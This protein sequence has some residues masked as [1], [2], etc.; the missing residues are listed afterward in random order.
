MARL[1][2]FSSKGYFIEGGALLVH[3]VEY[4]KWLS[5]Q[6]GKP[7]R[8]P[9]EAEWEYAARSAGEDEIWAGTSEE[10]QLSR[11][12]VCSNIEIQPQN[13]GSRKPNG[14]GVYDMSGNVREWVADC[15]HQNYDGAP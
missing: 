1:R 4:T 14:V 5:A 12:A 10:E 7:Y 2:N 15:W 8:L 13:V 9:T 6:T 3:P 11:Y